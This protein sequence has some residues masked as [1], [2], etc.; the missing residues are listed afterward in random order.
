MQDTMPLMTQAGTTRSALGLLVACGLL[1]CAQTRALH[2]VGPGHDAGEDP[3]PQAAD[4]AVFHPPEPPEPHP[5]DAGITEDS[6]LGFLARLAGD[7]IVLDVY[8]SGPAYALS[9]SGAVTL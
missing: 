7:D 3:P 6:P 4:A 8:G 9:C 2:G 1:G 5:R